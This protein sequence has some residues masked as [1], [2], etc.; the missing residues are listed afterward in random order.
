MNCKACGNELKIG[1]NE[2]CSHPTCVLNRKINSFESAP[3]RK[4]RFERNHG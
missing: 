3:K 1:E 4:T 2:Y